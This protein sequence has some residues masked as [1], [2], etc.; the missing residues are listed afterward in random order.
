MEVADIPAPGDAMSRA[1]LLIVCYTP[2]CRDPRVHRQVQALRN[3][4]RLTVIGHG[5]VP[6]TDGVEWVSFPHP[7][8]WPVWSRAKCALAL[9]AGFDTR[10]HVIPAWHD[11]FRR[12]SGIRFDLVL[13]ND[14]DTLPFAFRIADGA[15]VVWDA[16]EYYLDDHAGGWKYRWTV[17][18]HLA[19]TAR[20][21]AA[22]CRAVMTV[23]EGIAERYAREFGFRS[24]VVMNLPDAADLRPLPT[25]APPVPLRL[26]HHGGMAA[27]RSFDVMLDA[28]DMLGDGYCLDLFIVPAPG[29]A[30]D[31]LQRR[32]A[33]S[34]NARLLPPVP[35]PEIA[36]R[37][38]A[39]YDIGIHVLPPHSFNDRYALPNKFF[40]FI[41]ARLAVVVGPS[42]EMAG[43]VG[44]LGIGS[45]ADG[46]GAVELA[47]AVRSIPREK[48]DLCKASAHAAACE[49]HSGAVRQAIHRIVGMALADR[50]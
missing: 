25:P 12:L 40:E 30:W 41:Q 18:P 11:V 45:V 21:Y 20:R 36:S 34:R 17:L 1:H 35:M 7:G 33:A 46:F 31:R 42:P 28:I 5:P 3:D 50:S 37:L 26:V 43:M 6:A 27:S 2:L 15:P 44:R 23:S 16:H 19:R 22:R 32:V 9:F 47:A 48:I 4:Y 29:A 8:D 39:G 14:L 49:L 38:N 24:E 10:P 13:A